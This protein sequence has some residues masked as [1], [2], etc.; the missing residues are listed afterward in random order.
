[1]YRWS[2]KTKMRSLH[3][4][5]SVK[6]LASVT[7]TLTIII[8]LSSTSYAEITENDF[9]EAQMLLQGTPHLQSLG[10]ESTEITYVLTRN[11]PDPIKGL[12]IGEVSAANAEAKRDVFYEFLY[13]DEAKPFPKVIGFRSNPIIMFFLEWDIGETLN[14][15]TNKHSKT[16]LRNKIRAALWNDAKI[17]DVT[18]TYENKEHAGKRISISPFKENKRIDA[19]KKR[20][21]EFIVSKA[22]PGGFKSLMSHYEEDGKTIKTELSYTR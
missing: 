3:Y 22:V 15:T 8:G 1:M 21:Y 2:N 12:V 20:Q 10:A 6:L 7:K 16:V 11:G 14:S 13:N 19:V 5:S 17:E 9:S 18:I 4:Q